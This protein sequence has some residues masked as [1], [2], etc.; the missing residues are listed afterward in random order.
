MTIAV[1]VKKGGRT[2]I[3]ADSLVNFGGQRFPPENCQFHKIHRLGDSLMAWA[4]WS[5]YAELLTAHL[6]TNPPP[7][8]YTESEVFDFFVQAA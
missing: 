3:A 7:S 4:G 6:A 5:L 8:L 1:A 2:V